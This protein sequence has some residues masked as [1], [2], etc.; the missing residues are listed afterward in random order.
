MSST[1]LFEKLTKTWSIGPGDTVL[2]GKQ[3]KIYSRAMDRATLATKILDEKVLFG[4]K[5]KFTSHI[6]LAAALVLHRPEVGPGVFLF[7][8]RGG[9]WV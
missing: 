4:K 8:V 1:T 9:F 7:S 5:Q 6:S 3:Y 2:T